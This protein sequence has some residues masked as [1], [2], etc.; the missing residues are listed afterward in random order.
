MDNKK[1]AKELMK[2]AK[3]LTAGRG[4]GVEFTAKDV[5]GNLEYTAIFKRGKIIFKSNP[6]IVKRLSVNVFDAMGYDDGMTKVD[7]KKV[8]SKFYIDD[9]MVKDK[10]IDFIENAIG[11]EELKEDEKLLIDVYFSRPT[12]SASNIVSSRGSFKAGDE[13]TFPVEISIGCG[14]RFGMTEEYEIDMFAVF[15]LDGEYWWEDVFET[16]PRR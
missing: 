12:G 11:L 5:D 6:R 14:D 13:I 10:I 7:G 9:D 4:A 8:F 15:S 16:L 2:L 3:N 1:I